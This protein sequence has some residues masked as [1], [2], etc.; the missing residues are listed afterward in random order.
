MN[1]TSTNNSVTTA[2][3]NITMGIVKFNEIFSKWLAISIHIDKVAIQL[4]NE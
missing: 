3:L 4:T 2:Q 1:F